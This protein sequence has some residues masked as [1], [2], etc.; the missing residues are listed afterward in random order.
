MM[1]PYT[2][3]SRLCTRLQETED[4]FACATKTRKMKMVEKGGTR[5]VHLLSNT[6]PGKND[7]VCGRQECKCCRTRMR[8]KEMIKNKKEQGLCTKKDEKKWKSISN[9]R[10]EGIVYR[11][12]CITCLARQPQ[13]ER[14]YTG[15]SSRSAYLRFREHAQAVEVEDTK[16]H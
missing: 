11:T 13:T 8:I 1:V 7:R 14:T 15:I 2:P 9:C 3:D 10:R 12:D 6:D 16:Y 4:Q 5:L